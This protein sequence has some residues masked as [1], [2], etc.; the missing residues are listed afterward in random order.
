[1][2]PILKPVVDS[3]LR[4]LPHVKALGIGFHGIGDNWAELALPYAEHLVAYPGDDGVPGI[5]ASGAIFSL[6]DSVGGMAVVAKSKRMVR[7]ATLD[8][9]I[10]YLRPAEP[11]K[12]VIGRAEVTKLTRAVAFVKGIAHDGDPD[13]P[14]ALMT[15]SYMFT[16]GAKS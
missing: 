14:V 3:F 8:L 2:T 4:F 9:R 16:A 15:A 12:T 7:Q 13:D 1:M 11:G 10:D 6:M 5:I